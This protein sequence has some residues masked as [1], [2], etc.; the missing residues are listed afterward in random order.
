MADVGDEP[1]WHPSHLGPLLSLVERGKADS[2]GSGQ[3]DVPKACSHDHAFLNP[4][5]LSAPPPGQIGDEPAGSDRADLAQ[6]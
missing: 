6:R 5:N 3:Q 1:R 4:A 2:R